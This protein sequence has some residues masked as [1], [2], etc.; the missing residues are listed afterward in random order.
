[1]AEA[2]DMTTPEIEQVM[3][4]AM[5]AEDRRREL[6]SQSPGLGALV[7]LPDVP[8]GPGVGISDV[9]LPPIGESHHEAAPSVPQ[10]KSYGPPSPVYADSLIGGLNYA[11]GDVTTALRA[12]GERVIAT[13]DAAGRADVVVVSPGMA[14]RRSLL[15]RLAGRL[16]RH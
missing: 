16:R 11:P 14:P 6:A 12:A 2:A 5:T 9:P 4:A 1:V 10:I 13:Q 3:L 15:R 7:Q 8:Y